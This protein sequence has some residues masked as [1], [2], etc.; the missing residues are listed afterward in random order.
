MTSQKGNRLIGEYQRTCVGSQTR[1]PVLQRVSADASTMWRE[2][3]LTVRSCSQENIA[4]FIF[5]SVN[6]GNSFRQCRKI[7]ISVAKLCNSFGSSSISRAC[8]TV[9]VIG[10]NS[11]APR[12]LLREDWDLKRLGESRVKL[13]TLRGKRP[14]AFSRKRKRMLASRSRR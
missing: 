5:S 7:A 1:S 14:A 6:S 10:W 4:A 8:I 11:A 2:I 12:A 3:S 13:L 9:C